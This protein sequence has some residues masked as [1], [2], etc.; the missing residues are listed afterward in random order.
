MVS[1]SFQS[2]QNST[3]RCTGTCKDWVT[4]FLK[5]LYHLWSYGIPPSSTRVLW[6]STS[7]LFVPRTEERPVS[8]RELLRESLDFYEVEIQISS[9]P[10]L[11]QLISLSIEMKIIRSVNFS[12]SMFRFCKS[13][14]ISWRVCGGVNLGKMFH[15]KSIATPSI[16]SN[17]S[18][19]EADKQF[20]HLTVPSCNCFILSP[21][22]PRHSAESEQ[23]RT[24]ASVHLIT[25]S[26]D[27]VDFVH[28]GDVLSIGFTFRI[29]SECSNT[30]FCVTL[31]EFWSSSKFVFLYTSKLSVQFGRR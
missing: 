14:G 7:L 20:F 23:T 19:Q 2:S 18:R 22:L 11:V 29:Y 8:L 10:L 12:G 15:S 28:E 16:P 4:C 17:N 6:F 30:N 24:F 25:W 3:T 27:S 21:H 9:F 26:W 5:S 13:F 31:N 1:F